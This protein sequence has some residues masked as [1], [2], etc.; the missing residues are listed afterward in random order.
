VNEAERQILFGLVA[1]RLK[2]VSLAH[3]SRALSDWS[4][5]GDRS[6]ARL[7]IDR[8]Q[9]DEKSGALVE[10]AVLHHVT[11]AG[12]NAAS[13]LES[14]T[15]SEDLAALRQVLERTRRPITLLEETV[16]RGGSRPAPIP[17]STNGRS[18]V[19]D[20]TNVNYDQD[21]R[22]H[23]TLIYDGVASGG[24]QTF[25]ILRPLARGGLGEVFV[26]KDGRLNRE[27]ALKLID[28]SQAG[29]AQSKARFLLEAEITG[30]LEHP[31]IV[32]VYALGENS[33]GRLFYAMRLV[34]GE[35]LKDRIRKFHNAGSISRQ[36]VSFRQLLNHFVRICDIVAYAHSRGVL[37]RDLK[38]SN[39][40][41]G[42]FGETLVV[43]WGLAKPIETSAESRP[44]APDERAL[45]PVSG[46]S[47]QATLHGATLGTPQY[48][49]PEQALGQ[50]ERVGRV[51][52]VYGLGATLYCILTGAPPL[53][54]I[55]DVGEVLGRVAHGDIALPR[56]LK[57]DVPRTL[58][59]ICRKAMSVRQEE[60]Y[61][62]VRDLSADVESWLADEPAHGVSEPLARRIATWERKHRTFV[63]VAGL[64]LA[65]VAV[66]AVVAAFGVNAARERAEARRHE[67][68]ELARVAESRK[69][70]ADR[71]RDALRHLNTRLTLD[72]G[73]ALLDGNERRAGLLWLARSLESA[74]GQNDPFEPAI[75]GNLASW[76]PLLHRQRDCLE[77]RA[78]VRVIAW[79]PTGRAVATAS[80]DGT[81]LLWDPGAGDITA[82]ARTL[83]HHARVNAVAF[84]HDGQTLATGCEDQTARLWNTSSG[85]PRGEPMRHRGP[86]VSVFFN[87]D[88]SLVVT[89][90]GD[91]LVRNWDAMT[92]LERGKPL[93]HGKPL[94]AAT[95]S[96]D[97]KSIASVDL[98]G[99]V[100]V[101]DVPTGNP[102]V[103][104]RDAVIGVEALAF[105]PDSTKLACGGLYGQLVLINASEGSEIARTSKASQGDKVLALEWSHDGSRIATGHYD[106]TCRVWRGSD[107]VALGPKLE[108]RGRVW[109]VAFSPDDSLLAAA[110]DDNTVQL[111]NTQSCERAGD[112]LRH[113]Q[114]VRALS[115][116]PDGRLLTSGSDDKIARVWQLGGDSGIGQPMKHSAPVRVLAARPDGKAIASVTDDGTVWLWD[117]LTTRTIASSHAHGAGTQFELAFNAKGTVLV[118]SATDG[119]MR[120]WN[121][122]TLEPIGSVIKMPAWIRAIA[123]SPDG[124]SLAA[125][126]QSGRLGFW[127]VRTGNSLAPLA[128]L[129]QSVTTLAYHPDGT[130]LAVGTSD[131]EIRIWDASRF[132]PIGEAMRHQ[133]PVRHLEFSPDGTRLLSA[134]YDKTARLWNPT[135]GATIGSEMSHSAYVWRA[136]FNHDGERIVTAS[137]DGTA[138]IWNGR[139]GR[140][141][142]EPINHGDLVYDAVW[143]D[144]SSVVLTYGR[145]TSARLWNAAGS[146]PLGERL[147]HR[148]RVDGAIFVP[149]RP[150]V[151]TCSRDKTVRL[152][153]VPEPMNTSAQEVA[154]ETSVLTGMELGDDDILRL[155]DVPTWRSR[156]RALE[157]S[158]TQPQR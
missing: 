135:T 154:R 151:A 131:G 7:L 9:L 125:G 147:S 76:S 150:I 119:T 103:K 65:A 6:L 118:S 57:A 66:V 132:R 52:D 84:T 5:D 50:L 116:S 64:A 130:R 70:E 104:Q 120:L 55:S 91:G 111:W 96:P 54:D 37:H 61:P 114:P 82:S 88:D 134:S 97:G 75:R 109:A 34:R 3:V 129:N 144:D 86:V 112:S 58:E 121:G 87:P 16:G 139:T 32:P 2:L 148:V 155:L 127:D 13:S 43:D 142:G 110:A 128:A 29:D 72:R 94:R 78:P 19:R 56:S 38:P 99:G 8:K 12:G 136:R 25:E 71:Q 141:Q 133:A 45:R 149:G 39:V 30:G 106:T 140:P 92:G 157:A 18:N 41:L 122:A 90:S 36:P 69:L 21:D 153:A 40:M 123:I 113:Q 22:S 67:A 4:A 81:V 62:S 60:R 35:T 51:S 10:S 20:A 73:L 63:R 138:Q 33:D 156:R 101:W 124:S 42:K 47:V 152:W 100:V 1:I 115:F 23:G 137:F 26:A 95:K 145:S 17:P 83:E 28:G 126:D 15:G 46:S 31:G 14:F 11:M 74:S 68:D 79:S 80:D 93:D 143:S 77:H 107:L 24:G 89:A 102:R 85:L 98:T 59:A 117:A 158:P 105:S 27:V 48:M 146:R 108:H 53:H 44:A 49:S